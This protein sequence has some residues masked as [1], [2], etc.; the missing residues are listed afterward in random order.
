MTTILT[1]LTL[2]SCSSTKKLMNKDIIGK[3]Q[4]KGIYGVGSS[5]E[6]KKDKTFEYNWQ[7]GLVWGTTF[8]TWKREGKKIILNSE[9]QPSPSGIE[10]YEIIKTETNSS[11]SITIKILNPENEPL[12]FADCVL[13][14]D[15]S[16]VT[17]TSTNLQGEARFSLTKADSL[18]VMFV[19]YK[20]IRHKLDH[21]VTRYVFKLEEVNEFYEYFTN[22]TWTYKKDRLYDPSIKKGRYI[23]KEYYEKMK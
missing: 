2:L 9:L 18:I 11:D 22:D 7:T 17:G 14:S 15:T 20:T 10:D 19:G 13:K 6:L 23:K 4:W 21:E 3:Y 16:I 12:P 5:I 8:G 1:F